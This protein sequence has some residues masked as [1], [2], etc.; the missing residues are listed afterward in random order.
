MPCKSHPRC[1][2]RSSHRCTTFHKQMVKHPNEALRTVAG[3][4]ADW[5]SNPHSQF[6][7]KN[8]E[9][10]LLKLCTTSGGRGWSSTLI[11]GELPRCARIRIRGNRR[12]KIHKPGSLRK[13]SARASLC[14]RNPARV[15]TSHISSN[16]SMLLRCVL[17]RLCELY[18][19]PVSFLRIDPVG[20]VVWH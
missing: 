17:S 2:H 4:F 7:K 9:G 10:N 3:C 8:G 6:G 15:P 20:P 11:A 13:K 5:R 16:F 18:I 12:Q 1:S 14:G 19:V